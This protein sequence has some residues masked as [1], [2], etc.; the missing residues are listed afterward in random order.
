MQI[1]ESPAVR[2]TEKKE[3]EVNSS[4]FKEKIL[5]CKECG[6]RVYQP[7]LVRLVPSSL[8]P[9]LSAAATSACAKLP[10]AKR[11]PSEELPTLDL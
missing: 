8:K 1:K 4:L 7:V 6:L 3:Q 11:E 10:L 9:A 2:R 5:S